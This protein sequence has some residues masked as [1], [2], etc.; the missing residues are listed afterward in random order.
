LEK[1]IGAALFERLP[2]GVLLTSSGKV[3]LPHA[4]DIE[5]AFERANNAIETACPEE[6]FSVS[7]GVT[8][9]IGATILPFLLDVGDAAGPRI[10]WQA[11]QAA[12]HHLVEMILAEKID[13]A[14]AYQNPR[15]SNVRCFRLYS[16]DMALVGRPDVVG[17]TGADI[18]FSELSRFNLVLDRQSH[19]SRRVV[20]HAASK[21]NVE[22]NVQAE[23][24]PLSA[25]KSL[26]LDRTCCTIIPRG[27]FAT[28]I[29]NR[30]CVARRIVAPRLPLVLHLLV[31]RKLDSTRSGAIRAAV[32]QALASAPLL[33]KTTGFWPARE[34][35][36]NR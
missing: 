28:E 35:R 31:L 29:I 36:K 18:E 14:L 19:P 21:M 30:S 26:V 7:I 4:R 23:I 27:V 6:K 24:E 2:H 16:E 8:P 3:L 11:Q 9:T 34:L 5:A 33:T 25:K 17:R 32:R 1:S 22:L 20:D 12:S 10:D 15:R 13:A